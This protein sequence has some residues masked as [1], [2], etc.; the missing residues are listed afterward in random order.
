M[1]YIALTIRQTNSFSLSLTHYITFSPSQFQFNSHSHSQFIQ[2]H[3]HSTT[4][5]SFTHSFDHPLTH[6]PIRSASH[7]IVL[8]K[9]E[10]PHPLCGGGGWDWDTMDGSR[11]KGSKVWN[12]LR[13]STAWKRERKKQVWLCSVSSSLGAISEWCDSALN[14]TTRFSLTLYHRRN[15]AL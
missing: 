14:R 12:C 2:F 8:S 9:N 11:Q 1:H 13:P 7:L 4:T 15:R 5:Y 6:P 10:K 3:N